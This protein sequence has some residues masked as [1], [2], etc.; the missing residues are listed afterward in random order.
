M[1]QR[2]LKNSFKSP[3][4]RL[5]VIT[6]YFPTVSETFIRGHL[7]RLPASTVLIHSWPPSIGN[8]PVLSWP[9]RVYYKLRKRVSRNGGGGETSAAYMAAFRRF[10]LDAVLVEYGT[11]GVNVMEACRKLEIPLI[12][13]FHGY[14]ASVYEVLAKHAEDYPRMFGQAA[15][16]VA[17]SRSM[18]RKLISLGAP[19]EKVHY[20]PYGIDC[21][22][23]HGAEPQNSAPVFLAVGRFVEKKAPQVTLRAF[24]EVHRAAPAARLRMIGT[25]PLLDECRSLVQDL[26][27]DEAVTFLGAQPHIVVQEEMRTARAFVQHSVQASDGDCEGTPV[28]IMEAC[29]SGLPVISTRHAGIMDV[30]IE[31][32][33]GFLTDEHDVQGMTQHILRLTGDPELAGRMGRAARQRIEDHFSEEQSDGRLWE[34]IESCLAGYE[35]RETDHEASQGIH[36]LED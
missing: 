4:K 3:N 30:V 13:H 17:V 28:G 35:S 2:R 32:Q 6:P 23:F 36:G 1:D 8:S 12:V 20:N 18:E 27:I 5:G 25:G 9:T 7:D 29:A 22:Q 24:A 19:S 21:R 34:I 26:K 16:I 14:D 33:T 11:T 31:G 15:A 10:N